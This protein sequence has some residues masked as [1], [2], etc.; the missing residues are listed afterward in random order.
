MRLIPEFKFKENKITYRPM[1]TQE[2]LNP[3]IE[4]PMNFEPSDE[5]M[6]LLGHEKLAQRSKSM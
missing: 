3:Q 2:V 1:N 6:K 5:L 4:L